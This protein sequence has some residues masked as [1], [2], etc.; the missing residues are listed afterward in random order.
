VTQ[1]E[2]GPGE[3]SALADYLDRL[4]RLDSRAAVRIQAGGAVAGVWSGPPL[5]VVALRPVALAHAATVDVTVSATRL[6]ERLVGDERLP[7]P[8]SVPGPSWVGLLP[9]RSGWEERGRGS[10]GYLR[11]AVGQAK[12][13]FALRVDGVTDRVQL[14][15]AANEVWRRAC[16]AEVPVRAA[17]AAESLGLLG[18]GSGE[19]VAYAAAGWLRL[20]TPGGSVAVRREPVFG[21]SV[22]Q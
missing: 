21:L 18:P 14:D 1:L 9:P 15:A 13:A 12:Q 22:L 11:E 3:S 2:L 10:V 17:H 20:S 7:L 4:L 19:A 5:G 6:R 16:L 8:A